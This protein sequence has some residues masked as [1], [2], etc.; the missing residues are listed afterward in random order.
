MIKVNFRISNARVS[1][2]PPN[3]ARAN[4]KITPNRL[5][6]ILHTFSA[7]LSI[8]KKNQAHAHVRAFSFVISV[9][10]IE[11]PFFFLS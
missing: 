10:N 4:F 11:S 1:V 9:Y 5:K 8:S 2:R 6:F 7:I 3:Y